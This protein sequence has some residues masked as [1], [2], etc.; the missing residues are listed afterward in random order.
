MAK[1]VNSTKGPEAANVAPNIPKLKR[2]DIFNVGYFLKLTNRSGVTFSGE[3]K[4]FVKGSYCLINAEIVGKKYRVEA[5]WVLID[6]SA[7][8]HVF[9]KNSNLISLEE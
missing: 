5:P 6:I 1:K 3:F 8:S 4:G 9:P 2:E 7:V